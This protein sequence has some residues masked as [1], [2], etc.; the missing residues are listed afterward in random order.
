MSRMY[1][2]QQMSNFVMKNKCFENKL[3]LVKVR[4]K[5]KG[6]RGFARVNLIK[7]GYTIGCFRGF[8]PHLPYGL[9]LRPFIGG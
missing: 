5:E 4:K 1:N 3:Y 9:S 6:L 7:S 8:Q 2:P